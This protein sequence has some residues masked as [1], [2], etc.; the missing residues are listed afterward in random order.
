MQTLMQCL[1]E[2]E[3]TLHEVY[4]ERDALLAK[5]Q[6]AEDHAQLLA[7][8]VRERDA[9]L[10]AVGLDTD[11]VELTVKTLLSEITTGEFDAPQFFSRTP[12]V[13]VKP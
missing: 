6:E 4:Q 5:C 3:A 12:H 2:R 7:A 8:C 1:Q 11:T 13:R 9:A 10:Q